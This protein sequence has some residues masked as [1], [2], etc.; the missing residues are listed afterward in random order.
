MFKKVLGTSLLGA[1]ALVS[2]GA[3]EASADTLYT[4][5]EGDTVSAISQAFVGDNSLVDS[6]AESNKLEDVNLIFPGQEL[7]IPSDAQV[8]VATGEY[9]EPVQEEVYVEEPVEDYYVQEAIVPQEAVTYE[10]GGDGSVA[11][12]SQRMAEATGTSADYWNWI[13]MAESSGDSTITNPTGH[14]GYFQIA[15]VHGMPHGAS[16]DTQIEYAINIYNSQGF[17]A[18][19]VTH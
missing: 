7:N 2:L 18:W 3:V 12:A 1:L 6:I 10:T 15:P 16:V 8:A 11:Y 5:A 17:G 9:A 13:I 19:E 14:Y 4:V